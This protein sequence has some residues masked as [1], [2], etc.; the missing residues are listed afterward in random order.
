MLVAYPHEKD[1]SWNSTL[2]LRIGNMLPEN[3]VQSSVENER[4][5]K[6]RR[7]MSSGSR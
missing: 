7:K 1:Q 4:L 2:F 3:M 6:K 5:K